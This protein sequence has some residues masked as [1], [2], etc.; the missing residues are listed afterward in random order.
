[1]ERRPRC[2]LFQNSILPSRCDHSRSIKWPFAFDRHALA[3]AAVG[4]VVPER[5]MQGAAIIPKGHRAGAPLEA[6]LKF[7]TFGLLEQHLKQGVAFGFFEA[8]DAGCENA[9]YEE[10][11]LAADRMGAD[12][13]MFRAGVG[14]ARVIFAVLIAA[15]IPWLAVVE[16]GHARQEFSHRLGQGVE[17]RKHV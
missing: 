13:W 5:K 1:M 11:L 2:P 6:T 14:F 15:A 4:V 17:G 16:G 10:R 7:R 8:D 9:V 3:A 12:D